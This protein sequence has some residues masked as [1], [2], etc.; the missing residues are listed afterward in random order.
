L[1]LVEDEVGASGPLGTGVEVGGEPSQGKGN[2]SRKDNDLHG[3]VFARN[4]EIHDRLGR[5]HPT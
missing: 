2:Q 5:L 4:H 1:L 3:N